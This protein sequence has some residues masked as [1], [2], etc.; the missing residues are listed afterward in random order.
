MSA[1]RELRV[2][3]HLGGSGVW[4]ESDE[5]G[6]VGGLEPWMG[7][8]LKN[9]DHNTLPDRVLQWHTPD[10]QADALIRSAI[11]RIL[12]EAQGEHE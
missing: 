4:L 3:R 6:T 9:R 10:I 5:E 8:W 11:S 2:T 7:E 12:K 1:D